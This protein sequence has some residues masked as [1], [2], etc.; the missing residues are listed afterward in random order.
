MSQ[1]PVDK[2][3]REWAASRQPPEEHLAELADRVA[4]KVRDDRFLRVP[5]TPSPAFGWH[6]VPRLAYLAAGIAAGILLAVPLMRSAFERT[7]DVSWAAA[8]KASVTEPILLEKATLFGQYSDVFGGGVRWIAETDNDVRM[9]LATDHTSAE[10]GRVVLVRVSVLRRGR[11][12]GD[13]KAVWDTTVSTR[14]EE[15]VT[16]NT[17]DGVGGRLRL[18]VYPL[19]DGNIAMDS[20]LHLDQPTCLAAATSAVMVPGKP[21]RVL[22]LQT[23]TAEYAVVQVASWLPLGHR[24]KSS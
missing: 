14:S 10:P 23:D 4:Q 24:S 13:W 18:W 6:R 22:A 8:S 11:A 21:M 1:H 15:S 17:D 7:A 12:G 5:S 9:G 20:E 19:P 3:V 2:H 16:L